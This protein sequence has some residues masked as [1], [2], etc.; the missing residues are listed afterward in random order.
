MAAPLVPSLP[1]LGLLVACAEQRPPEIVPAPEPQAGPVASVLQGHWQSTGESD[2]GDCTLTIQGDSLYFYARPDFQYDATI[3]LIPDTD[4]AEFHATILD[5]PRT[6]DSAGEVVVA[7]YALEDGGLRL[8]AVD[9]VEGEVPSFD[10]ALSKYRF[11]RV[12]EAD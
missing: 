2:S 6:T 4:P 5:T 1:L 3:E 11:E 10:R 7:I 8:A 9:K 12:A